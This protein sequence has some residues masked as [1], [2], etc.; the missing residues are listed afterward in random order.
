MNTLIGLGELVIF[1]YM[2]NRTLRDSD[3]IIYN[4]LFCYLCQILNYKLVGSVA[5]ISFGVN[6]YPSDCTILLMIFVWIVKGMKIKKRLYMGLVGVFL[7]MAGQAAIRG[8]MTFG[9][10]SELWGDLRKF[11]YFGMS[12]LYFY[13]VPIKRPLKAFERN[14]YR[15][16][17]FLTIYALIIVAFYF[18][19][20]PLGERANERPLLADFA[21]I[22]AAFAAYN[23][24]KDLILSA[25]PE[26]SMKT[27]LYTITL[28]LNRF[29]TTWVALLVSLGVLIISR[30]RDKNSTTLSKKF[31]FQVAIIAILVGIFTSSSNVIMD[32]LMESTAKFDMNEDNTFSGRIELWQSMMNFV[33]GHYALIGYPFGS[34]FHAYYRGGYWQASP[35]N[36]YIES[37]LRTGYIG[38]VALV[39]SIITIM[40]QAFVKRNILPIMLC[41]ICM[42]FW[43]AYSLTFEQ[44]V[45]IGLC[46]HYVFRRE[47]Q[48]ELDNIY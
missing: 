46:A 15:V 40:K 47:V 21:I 45:L 12:I 17:N 10:S 9:M 8:L 3:N 48:Y 34:G 1:L 20:M 41:A 26:I 30:V 36:G 11:L 2:A 16:F 22:Y 44:G 24:Y 31:Y 43:G 37:L 7:I 39:I 28:I 42:T 14:V 23:W 18:A 5:W 32:R 29:N 33:K 13:N 27:I 35:H 6:L 25:K 4:I 38:V 19:G